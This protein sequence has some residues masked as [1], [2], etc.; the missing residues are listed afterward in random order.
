MRAPGPSGRSCEPAKSYRSR[1][2]HAGIQQMLECY[3]TGKAEY[4][5]RE[6]LKPLIEDIA[7]FL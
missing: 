2:L 6:T 1:C 7:K 4:I 3:K 5:D